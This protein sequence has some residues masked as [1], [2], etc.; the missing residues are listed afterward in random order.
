[1]QEILKVLSKAKAL[2]EVT[3]PFVFSSKLKTNNQK[4]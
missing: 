1:M 3:L 2:I 4:A